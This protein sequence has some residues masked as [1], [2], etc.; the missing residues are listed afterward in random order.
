M[1]L[2]FESRP[3]APRGEAGGIAGMRDL[4]TS[5]A[6][7]FGGAGDSS[8]AAVTATLLALLMLAEAAM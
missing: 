4:R 3:L 7:D 5:A 6:W 8:R 2:G 1:A